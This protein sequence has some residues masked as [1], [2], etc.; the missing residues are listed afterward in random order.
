MITVNGLILQRVDS[1]ESWEYVNPILSNRELGYERSIYNDP[2]GVKMGD[3]VTAWNS[4]PYWF[5]TG[6]GNGNR[7]VIFPGDPSITQNLS[8]GTLVLSWTL[9]LFAIFGNIEATIKVLTADGYDYVQQPYFPRYQYTG[10]NVT[11]ITYNGFFDSDY[12]IIVTL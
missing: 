1:T 12:K 5:Q 4:L 10:M 2:V 6:S 8:T 3:G 7:V 11:L 9:S